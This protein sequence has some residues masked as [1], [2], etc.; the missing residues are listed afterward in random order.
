ML[1]FRAGGVAP[2]SKSEAL[3]SIPVKNSNAFIQKMKARR[4]RSLTVM[5]LKRKFILTRGKN[6]PIINLKSSVRFFT[7]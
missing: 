7:I 6:L 1:S 4:K 2:P 5:P 3:S